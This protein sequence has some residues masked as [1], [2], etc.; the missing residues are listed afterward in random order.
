MMKR[1]QVTL[2]IRGSRARRAPARSAALLLA[3]GLLFA[4]SAGIAQPVP[5]DA[6]FSDFKPTGDF[7]FDLGGKTLDNA[8]IYLS[9]RAAAYLVIAPELASPILIS[10]RTQSVE[11]VSFMKVSKRD[12]GTIDLLADASFDRLGSFSI[13]NQEVVFQVKGQ[14]AK[15]KA[16]PPLLGK[17]YADGLRGYKPEYARL[18]DGYNPAAPS[19]KALKEQ[20]QDVRVLVYFGTWCPVCGRL[21]PRIIKV[22]EQLAGS[23]VTFDYYGLPQPMTDDP[24][25]ERENVRSVPTAVVYSGGKE[26]GRLSGADL[27]TPEKSIY[28]LINGA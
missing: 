24:V 5:A 26:I 14:A 19:L 25:T 3:A 27:N 18:A 17:Q 12:D 23:K 28:K 2:P 22:E 4:A 11:S 7:L 8:E 20:G 15:L 6:V 21:V 16:R 9:D 13:A 1:D 10:P